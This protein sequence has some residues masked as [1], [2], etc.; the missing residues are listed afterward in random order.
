MITVV[1]NPKEKTISFSGHAG[2]DDG[3]RDIVCAA[4]SCLYYIIEGNCRHTHPNGDEN[5]IRLKRGIR[6]RIILSAVLKILTEL[7]RTYPP[8]IT[9]EKSISSTLPKNFYL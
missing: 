3:G 9:L 4:V 6:E 1:Y 5:I 7:C 2:Y 8:N